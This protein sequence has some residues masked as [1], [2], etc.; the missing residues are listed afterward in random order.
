MPTV[1]FSSIGRGRTDEFVE[2]ETTYGRIKGM[3]TDGVNLFKG[4][5]Y[6]GGL[7]FD[8]VFLVGYPLEPD[9]FSFLRWRRGD[10]GEASCW[11]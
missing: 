4:I 8:T 2:T 10:V 7:F 5:P 9:G 6:A 1:G 3:R 11:G